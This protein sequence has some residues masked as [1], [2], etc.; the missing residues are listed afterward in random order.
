M[1]ND[2][3]FQ[4]KINEINDNT[5]NVKTIIYLIQMHY[6]WLYIYNF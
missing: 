1:W 3:V 4:N 5:F 6:K 2:S